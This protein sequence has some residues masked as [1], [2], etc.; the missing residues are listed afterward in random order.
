MKNSYFLADPYP[1]AIGAEESLRGRPDLLLHWGACPPAFFRAEW[2]N[3]QIHAV[4]VD[5]Q[6]YS[7]TLLAV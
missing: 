3:E 5:V 7:W 4:M 1:E 6:G 2:P